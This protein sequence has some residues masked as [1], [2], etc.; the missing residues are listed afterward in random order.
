MGEMTHDDFCVLCSLLTL[1]EER[2]HLS[3]GHLICIDCKDFLFRHTDKCSFCGE[4]VVAR[5][6]ISHAEMKA[7]FLCAF[8]GDYC[9]TNSSQLVKKNDCLYIC[10]TCVAYHDIENRK[11]IYLQ[12]NKEWSR[13]SYRV[14]MKNMAPICQD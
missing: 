11:Y 4:Y 2:C 10:D 7:S 14:I 5:T 9:T 3:C 13:G 6:I 8:C 1:D 12:F